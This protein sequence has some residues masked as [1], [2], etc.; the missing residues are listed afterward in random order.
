MTL[1]LRTRLLLTVAPLVAL[2]AA[3]GIAGVFLLNN[4]GR[5]SEEIIRENYV[6]LE[7][8]TDLAAQ[9]AGAER[10]VLTAQSGDEWRVAVAHERFLFSIRRARELCR[11]E[12]DNLTVPGE[13]AAAADLMLA[14]D[15]L[16][17]RGEKLFAM[18]DTA[19]RRE[20]YERPDTGYAAGM[21]AAIDHLMT[22]RHLNEQAMY[23]A[24]RKARETAA[25][26]A[27]VLGVSSAV[28]VLLAVL[29]IWW[30]NR[31]LLGP[32]RTVT[33]AATAIGRGDLQQLVPVLTRD[34]VGQL[35]EAFNGMA[36][37]LRAYRQ[38][39]EYQLNRARQAAQ[40]T[41]DAFPDPVLVI[42]PG[43]RV[44]VA[45]PAAVRLFGTT[46]GAAVWTPPDSL[47]AVLADAAHGQ[48]VLTESFDQVVT[49][50]TGGEEHSY[51]PQARPI[52]AA[53][54]EPLG[55]AVVLNDI[56]RFRL[57]DQLKSDWV[58][59]VSHEL[60]TPLSG[61]QLAVHVLLDEVIGPLTPK[62]TEL[63]LDARDN[64]DRLMKLIHQLLALA[65]LEDDRRAFELTPADP[66][67]LLRAAADA[68][69]TR[70][71][72]KHLTLTVDVPADLPAVRVDAV[73][74]GQAL[75]NLLDNAVA[76]TPP[77]GSVTLAARFADNA[78]S[79]TVADT[80][81]GIPP[82]DLPHVFE[83]FFRVSGRDAPGT[84]L[85]L[86]IVREVVE[87]HG[88]RI[89]CESAEG[90]GT[91]FTITLP[92]APGEHA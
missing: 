43:G 31:T 88:G 57:L 48:P 92:A 7:L 41:V 22:V 81:V 85:G 19:A 9:L 91:M 59:T 78:V 73:R 24:D 40:A 6:S 13:R 14:V 15:D 72:D 76:H 68:V 23:D 86:A 10:M 1:S 51:L 16:E 20:Y 49:F 17:Q 37:K 11:K 53:D 46:P 75:N 74:F 82:A 50:Q 36:A 33:A 63:L 42:D 52:A 12:L 47:R 54:G 84:G 4:L 29:A 90:K 32:I 66:A 65:K 35:A 71:E 55:V 39:E 30:L 8:M 18:P 89:R 26:S 34:E 56:T 45:N 77:G 67:A 3:V 60:K 44:E 27:W 58:A 87:G 21:T 70:A 83:R 64:A 28:A 69:A 2:I 79:L 62:Q 80:G 38:T 25:R 61:V 5:R